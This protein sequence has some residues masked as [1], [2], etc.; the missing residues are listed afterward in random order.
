[1]DT[2]AE[3]L[4]ADDSRFSQDGTGQWWC[5]VPTQGTRTRAIVAECEFCGRRYLHEI[6]S[7][8]RRFCSLL[9]AARQPD[10]RRRTAPLFKTEKDAYYQDESDQWWC[11]TAR[12]QRLRVA[13]RTC[14]HCGQEF[15]NRH[16]QRFCTAV[17][18][19]ASTK[20]VARIERPDLIC[21]ECGK[22][23]E[24]APSRHPRY[25]AK[26]CSRE[27]GIKAGNKKRGRP[28]ELNCR[29]KGGI[30]HHKAGY[31]L[32]YVDPERKM[33][34]EHRLVMEQVL[35]RPLERYE[36]VHHKNGVRDDNRP[37]NLE[38]WVKRQPGG[39][40]VKDLIEHARWV[41]ERYA[42]LDLQG[43]LI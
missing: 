31:K 21:P 15:V 11:Q 10:R 25:K 9:C 38:L 34:L 17:C 28:G 13:P 20:G 6:G 1:M 2:N 12:G 32:R 23:F 7:R 16:P 30:K 36:E 27:C 22:S 19:D 35:G 42:P 43:K 14:E 4:H 40:R 3:I 39:Q 24:Q 5:A 37:E 26:H 33:V 29:W 18:R 8:S 41:L